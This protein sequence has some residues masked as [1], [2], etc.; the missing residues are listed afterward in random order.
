MKP[1]KR[2]RLRR[3]FG[4]FLKPFRRREE[5]SDTDEVWETESSHEADEDE[6]IV[7]SESR[8]N[9]A[10]RL[11]GD[12]FI[13]SGEAVYLKE[14]VPLLGLSER[15]SVLLVGAGTG[16]A[17]QMIVEDTGAWVTGYETREEIAAIGKER[18]RRAGMTKRAPVNFK[19]FGALKLKERAFDTCIS[20]ESL[21]LTPDKKA[22][23]SAIFDSM[24]DNA[25]L[26]YTDFALPDRNSPNDIVQAWS[27]AQP[28]AVHLWP[29][30]VIQTL[31][32]NT[33]FDVKLT[34][35]ITAA[36][37]GRIFDSLFRFLASTNKAELLEIADGVFGELERLAK[38]VAA[39]DSGG[40]KV[41]RFHAFKPRR[42]R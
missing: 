3:F 18:I 15:N 22:A 33:G 40:M 31:L 25:E 1:A 23:F 12:G 35:D 5:I 28:D 24:R 17:G 13:R 21:Y 34:E 36:Y 38:L 10:E 2:T 7:W 39:L 4:W 8:L 14:F 16:G 6:E 41:Y 9:I 27:D 11:W 32:R 20:L 37:R 29:A 26:W 42:G 19:D 30:D